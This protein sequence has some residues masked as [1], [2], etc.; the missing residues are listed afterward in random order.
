MLELTLDECNQ[1]PD[2]V[3]KILIFGWIRIQPKMD[4]IRNPGTTFTLLFLS[5]STVRNYAWYYLYFT[6]FLYIKF[7]SLV[8]LVG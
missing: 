5:L 6:H 3:F 7:Y 1:D 8:K 2:P 4:L